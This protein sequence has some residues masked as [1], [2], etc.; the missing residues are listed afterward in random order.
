[1]AHHVGLWGRR[2]G[3]PLPSHGL[4][5]E[6]RFGQRPP[7]SLYA[8]D[9]S[10][11]EQV[12]ALFNEAWY[13]VAQRSW[14][15]AQEML[16]ELLQIAPDDGEALVLLAKVHVALGSF[17]SALGALDAARDVGWPVDD[18]L[19]QAIKRRLGASLPP[20]DPDGDMTPSSPPPGVKDAVAARQ[21]SFLLRQDN[22]GLHDKVVSLEKEVRRWIF[23]TMGVC[24]TATAL[25]TWALVPPLPTA[26]ASSTPAL[27]PFLRP[28]LEVVRPVHRPSTPLDTVAD[29]VVPHVSNTLSARVQNGVAFAEGELRDYREIAAIQEAWLELPEV[30]EVDWSDVLVHSRVQG[31]RVL[32]TKGDTLSDI[33]F[34]YYGDARLTAPIEK[35]NDVTA[36]TLRPGQFLWVPP[37]LD[38]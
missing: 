3:G 2:Q 35:Q 26:A 36:K 33:A 6:S 12:A 16:E 9:P 14:R 20:V 38:Q 30:H 11:E 29:R 31:G 17:P 21:R 1:M 37:L 28:G 32:V 25:V 10:N 15:D 18:K 7:R 4:G 34:R 23:A 13:A 24:V 27:A 8:D 5:P 19:R 22:E